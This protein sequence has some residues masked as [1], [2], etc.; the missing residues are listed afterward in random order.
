V[1]GDPYPKARQLARG[2]R[3]YRRKI[4]SPKAWQ[5]ITAAK[6]G[7]CRVC[8]DPC[9]NGRMYGRITFHHLV[10]RDFHGDDAPDNIVPLCQ[11]CHWRVT[12]LQPI[13]CRA[14]CASLTDAE[15]AYAVEKVGEDVFERIYGIEYER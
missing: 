11:D 2:Q 4:A 15:Y 13:P 5:A 14:L 12:A 7:P 6:I 8:C 1:S 10:P 3:R 9:A